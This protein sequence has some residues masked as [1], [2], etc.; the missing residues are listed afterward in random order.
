MIITNQLIFITLVYSTSKRAV[1]L[2]VHDNLLRYRVNL[3]IILSTDSS[4]Y[5]SLMGL[6]MTIVIVPL[7]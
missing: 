2:G 5:I 4:S 7:S 3:Y 1:V 6:V